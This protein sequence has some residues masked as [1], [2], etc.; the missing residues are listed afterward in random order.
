MKCVIGLLFFFLI[1]EGSA[2]SET[3]LAKV[4]AFYKSIDTLEVDF[5]QEIKL[6]DIK[7]RIKL[8]GIL[9]VSKPHRIRWEIISPSHLLV[10]I[11]E[12]EISIESGEGESKTVQI[13]K[14]GDLVQGKEGQ[15]VEGLM[16]WL[17]MNENAILKKYRVINTGS[18][19]FLF[20]PYTL[21]ISKF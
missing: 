4:F 17:W 2:K 3:S 13:I 7:S 6:K 11:N 9:K 5:H 21:D 1:N 10:L 14:K 20:I 18:K 8:K 19:D 15:L 16:N 12:K